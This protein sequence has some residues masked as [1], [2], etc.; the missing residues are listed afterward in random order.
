MVISL[1]N[2][3]DRRTNCKSYLEKMDYEWMFFDAVDG[4]KIDN[5]PPEYNEKK[6]TVC[7]E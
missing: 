5:Y 1:K 4:K 2:S 7:V 3:L 6:V